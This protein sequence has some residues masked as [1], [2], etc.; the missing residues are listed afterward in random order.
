MKAFIPTALVCALVGL[1]GC[2]TV[3]VRPI[4]LLSDYRTAE[5]RQDRAAP[6]QAGR[7][8]DVSALTP[9]LARATW[10]NDSFF[11][12]GGH[13]LRYPDGRELFMPSGFEFFRERGVPGSFLIQK[14]DVAG[15]QKAMEAIRQR[16]PVS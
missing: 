3:R 11:S 1:A 4:S 14:E 8:V 16:P 15:Y 7:N 13:W 9:I 5:L 12:K 6:D 2:S 10:T